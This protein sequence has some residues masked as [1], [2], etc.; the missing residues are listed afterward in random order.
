[1]GFNSATKDD[2]SMKPYHQLSRQASDAK[3]ITYENKN[4]EIYKM[5]SKPSQ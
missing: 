3:D 5:I 1:M 2:Y 4:I